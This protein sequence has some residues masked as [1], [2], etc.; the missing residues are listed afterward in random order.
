VPINR[1]VALVAALIALAGGLLPVILNADWQSS[2]GI[3]VAI[4]AVVKVADR[5][6]IG[7]QNHELDLGAA[8][9][10]AGITGGD[11][12]GLPP[13]LEHVAEQLR[14]IVAHVDPKA[15]TPLTGAYQAVLQLDRKAVV[16]LQEA[17]A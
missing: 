2:A 8:A 10:A 7:W 13:E 4:A 16:A 5:W 3:L 11:L 12:P 14:A 9:A 1:I 6:L 17:L 15:L